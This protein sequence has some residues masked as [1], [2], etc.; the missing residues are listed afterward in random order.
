VVD[1]GDAE[2]HAH[3]HAVDCDKAHARLLRCTQ[4]ASSAT[5]TLATVIKFA[6]VLQ[7]NTRLEETRE[8]IFLF[9][10]IHQVMPKRAREDEVLDNRRRANLLRMAAL[11]QVLNGSDRDIIEREQWL[12]SE[13]AAIASETQLID[14]AASDR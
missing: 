1:T 13:A 2:R 9:R 12:L 11:L 8:L 10:E 3:T 4:G 7:L 6:E 5:R 14:L